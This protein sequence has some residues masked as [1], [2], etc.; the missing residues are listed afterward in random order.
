V[1]GAG[2][3]ERGGSEAFSRPVALVGPNGAGK[4][5]RLWRLALP[6]NKRARGIRL[7][8][9]NP[10]DLFTRES[11]A[12]ECRAQDRE[13]LNR[14]PAVGVGVNPS[15]RE[16]L[17]NLLEHEIDVNLHP[18]DL[19]TG[20]QR[21]LAIAL[22]LHERPRTLL[23]DEPTRGLDR[24]ACVELAQVLERVSQQ[25]TRV[26]VATHD[27]SFATLINARVLTLAPRLEAVR[28]S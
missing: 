27:Q 6:A 21:A 9:E 2:A 14:R 26:I 19:S 24:R 5:T 15:S 4:T 22:Q 12:E 20:Q 10:R 1:T 28:S 3:E 11:V 16:L 18:R 8:P 17:H 25:G 23:I 7:V 13:H